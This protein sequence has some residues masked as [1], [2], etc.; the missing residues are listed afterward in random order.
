[1]II[2]TLLLTSIWNLERLLKTARQS[3][4]FTQ[5]SRFQ[6]E[7]PAMF[8][9]PFIIMPYQYIFKKEKVKLWKFVDI[10]NTQTA[11][12]AAPS[13]PGPG[14]RLC[15]L[16]SLC[17]PSGRI[18]LLPFKDFARF[19]DC[20]GSGRYKYIVKRFSYFQYISTNRNFVHL[21][22]ISLQSWNFWAF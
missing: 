15:P 10:F 8:L 22:W 5:A 18:Y 7:R 13:T 6:V 14:R 20:C 9:C 17:C 1:M 21:F 4:P 16:S 3:I 2:K 11:K 19:W 12:S